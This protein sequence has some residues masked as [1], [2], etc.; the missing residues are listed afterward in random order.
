M[1]I[2]VYYA[3]TMTTVLLWPRKSV[4]SLN[5]DQ[6]G[7]IRRSKTYDFIIVIESKRIYENMRLKHQKEKNPVDI[8]Y[9][10]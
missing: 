4:I 5:V 9:K 8:Y 2:S 10:I 3:V 1:R 6:Y 7:K